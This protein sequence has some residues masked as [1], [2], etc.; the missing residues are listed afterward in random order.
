MLALSIKYPEIFEKNGT[1]IKC[2]SVITL[3][4][5]EIMI[6]IS[7]Y[8]YEINNFVDFFSSKA[9]S[10][11]EL[12][13]IVKDVFGNDK[14][15]LCRLLNKVLSKD[16]NIPYQEI[17]PI[18]LSRD[19][20]FDWKNAYEELV[21]TALNKPKYLN[22]DALTAI[23]RHFPFESPKISKNFLI[24][25]EISKTDNM[26]KDFFIL[27]ASYL[28]REH[29]Y[30]FFWF[31]LNAKEDNSFGANLDERLDSIYHQIEKQKFRQVKESDNDFM[32]TYQYWKLWKTLF[33]PLGS[34]FEIH[35]SYRY[36]HE[37]E[38]KEEIW[39]RQSEALEILESHPEL[40]AFAIKGILDYSRKYWDLL[41]PVIIGLPD[42]IVVDTLNKY[43]ETNH[44]HEKHYHA[45]RLLSHAKN[46]I[47]EKGAIYLT[48]NSGLLEAVEDL[49]EFSRTKL[50]RY[51]G[52]TWL[53]D[54][55]VENL[56]FGAINKASNEFI[57]Y[58]DSQ[59][60]QDE[61]EHVSVLIETLH[62]NFKRLSQV[63]SDWLK[64]N[65]SF[66][67]VFQT[68]I[69]RFPKRTTEG[70]PQEGGERGTQAD[71]AVILKCDI[72]ELMLTERITFFQAKK[73]GLIPKTKKWESSI[74][75]NQPQLRKA[76]KISEHF[77]YLFFLHSEI[78]KCP[79]I[80][81]AQMIKDICMA[82]K[83]KKIPVP[84]ILRAAR[85]FPRFFLKDL[86]GLWV[87]DTRQ[88]VIKKARKGCD[89]GQAPRIIL[90]VSIT[91]GNAE[92]NIQ[93]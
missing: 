82:H 87:G 34:L 66:P 59:Y 70:Y 76:L 17:I 90:E 19:K 83:M 52:L 8:N 58:F 71:M 9:G 22:D 3:G 92:Q 68:S 65:S 91:K 49:Y 40:V 36:G 23:I 89:I 18:W 67:A 88:G 39:I 53:G 93:F 50:Q 10:S 62:R 57:D 51:A 27:W 81:P 43:L 6:G 11:K 48:K 14:N 4:Y 64:H 1:S 47:P 13:E 56:T 31:S 84:I 63:V 15:Q 46:R 21:L 72:P 55:A 16:I 38:I 35:G 42:E 44:S 54:A 12:S 25:A 86:I 30:E 79:V 33:R 73:V 7:S 37:V 61:H 78:G 45:L 60:G 2:L 5:K 77:Y 74:S 69:K 80:L 20:K 75:I 32:G 85:E 41:D 28:V 29:V 26:E 24:K